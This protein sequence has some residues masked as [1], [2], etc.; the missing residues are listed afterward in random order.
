MNNR[1]IYEIKPDFDETYRRMEAYWNH[2]VLDRPIL[3]ATLQP[4]KD[5]PYT[6]RESY[7]DRVYGDLDQILRT[8]LENARHT[9]YLGEAVP[10]LWTS[11]GTHEIATF[12]GYDVEWSGYTNWCKHDPRPLEE[13]LPI[14]LQ[15][16]SFMYRRALEFYRKAAAVLEGR[17]LPYGYDFHSN[18]DF[19]LSIRGDANLCMD[20]LDCPEMVHKGLE[21]SCVIFQKIWSEFTEASKSEEYGYYFEYFSEKPITTLAC[22]F[23]ALIGRE[24]FDEFAVP[25]LTYESEVIGER[26]VF[27]WDG[28]AALKHKDSLIKI[29]N[30]HTFS[31]VPNHYETHTQMLELYSLCQQA[32]KGIVFTGSP[33]E[34]KNASKTLKPNQTIYHTSVKDEREFDEL[35]AWL[36]AHT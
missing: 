10:G 33:E 4:E 32:G 3:I 28:P 27:H 21:D 35:A 17:L 6:P 14:R 11:L 25:T 29:E 22:D 1:N 34:I 36:K 24:M 9:R 13:I 2:D 5:F 16:D 20:T 8:N 18:L 23:A 12:C 7:Y 15:E 31:Y 19:L 26:C 30:L